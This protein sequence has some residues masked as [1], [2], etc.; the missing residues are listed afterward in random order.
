[1]KENSG[2]SYLSSFIINQVGEI[3]LPVT[4][5]GHHI[6][7]SPYRVIACQDYSS[8]Q[9]PVNNGGKMGKAFAIAC[10]DGLWVMTYDSHN[11]VYVFDN[12]S[13]LIKKFGNKGSSKRQFH[14]PH[15][16][17]FGANG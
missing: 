5:D 12:Y 10:D 13:K 11:C 14:F 1:M 4:I 2:G 9:K 8:M 16:L 15:G 3:K 7:G 17:A 6:K